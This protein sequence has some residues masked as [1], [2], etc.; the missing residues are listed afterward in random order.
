MEGSATSRCK[1]E[2]NRPPHHLFVVSIT[3]SGDFYISTVSDLSLFIAE[4]FHVR[5][6]VSTFAPIIGPPFLGPDFSWRF[7]VGSSNGS[8]L[9]FGFMASQSVLGFVNVATVLF[10]ATT[11]VVLFAISLGLPF[12]GRCL[13]RVVSTSYS[14]G[15]V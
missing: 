11:H 12:N 1:T 5:F 15:V 7:Y 9:M 10:H 6:L 2:R 3:T 4:F 8:V 13:G 14:I